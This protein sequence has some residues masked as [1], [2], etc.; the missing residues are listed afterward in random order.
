MRPTTSKV[1]LAIISMLGRKLIAGSTVLELFAG[2]GSVGFELF[3]LG[4]KKVVMIEKDQRQY[5]KTK[6]RLDSL[7]TNQLDLIKGDV[8]SVVKNLKG[9]FNIIFADTPY[10]HKLLPKIINSIDRTGLAA[11]NALIIYE[12][13]KK[14]ETPINYLGFHRLRDKTYGDSKVSIYKKSNESSYD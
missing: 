14:T 11:D 8:F 1:K 2:T 5:I 13:Y 3:R 9:K 12:H 4:A 10:E 6:E 7:N